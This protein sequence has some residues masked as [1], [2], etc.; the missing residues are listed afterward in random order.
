MEGCPDWRYMRPLADLSQPAAV[1]RLQWAITR[2]PCALN[3]FLLFSV[4]AKKKKKSHVL[5]PFV[6]CIIVI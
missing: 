4:F 2:I 6:D 3:K 5:L 1:L